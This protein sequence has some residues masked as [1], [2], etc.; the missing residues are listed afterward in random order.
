MKVAA[1]AFFAGSLVMAQ[2][3]QAAEI[4]AFFSG[5]AHRSLDAI[6]PQF[7]R[8]SGHKVSA[9]YE[10]PPSLVKR[11]D[12]GEPFDVL[13][14]SY[15]VAGLVKQG[16]LAEGSRT[17]LGRIGVGVAVR[18]GSPKPDFGSV[19]KFKR[20]LLG[21]KSFATSGQGS[22]GRYVDGLIDRLGIPQVKSKIKSGG[23]GASAKMLAA[24]EVDFV[25]SG[26]PPLL[27]TPNIEWLGYLPEEI[28]NW[29]VF[30][31][32]L[33][34]HAKEPEAGRA[35]LK[36]LTSPPAVAVWKDNGLEPVQ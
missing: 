1:L 7:E 35:L 22:S 25:V 10:L 5:A 33:S 3:S 31:G 30:S 34:A 21:A 32:G 19:E 24:G 6:I 29:L 16:K 36:F 15:D 4:R 28:N 2:P 13:I 8:E 26:L 14:L 23:P 18:E 20:M 12:A 27:G 9:L 11:V 17:A